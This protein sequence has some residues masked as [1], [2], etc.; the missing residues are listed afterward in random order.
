MKQVVNR[1]EHPRGI[2]EHYCRALPPFVLCCLDFLFK[3]YR[4][5]VDFVA[6]GSSIV[7]VLGDASDDPLVK[8]KFLAQIPI[9]DRIEPNGTTFFRHSCSTNRFKILT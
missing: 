2:A 5:A 3:L 9:G 1:L 7:L 4:T 6:L 8:L